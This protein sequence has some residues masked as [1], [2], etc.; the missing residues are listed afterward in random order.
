M[1]RINGKRTMIY[2]RADL[3]PTDRLAAACRR[4]NHGPV[5]ERKAT[6]TVVSGRENT[7]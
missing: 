6:I 2:A 5:H 7:R 3:S 4:C 1:W